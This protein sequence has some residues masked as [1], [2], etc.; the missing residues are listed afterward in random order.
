MHRA[1]VIKSFFGRRRPICL[2]KDPY[3]AANNDRQSYN[4]N[5]FRFH[6]FNFSP[7]VCAWR[8]IFRNNSRAQNSVEQGEKNLKCAGSGHTTGFNEAGSEKQGAVARVQRRAGGGKGNSGGRN[9]IRR[10]FRHGPNHQR[11]S[12][13]RN[14]I[15]CVGLRDGRRALRIGLGQGATTFLAATRRARNGCRHRTR[16]Q[17]QQW[18]R[19][20][21]DEQR[22]KQ[23]YQE[24][25]HFRR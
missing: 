23:N 13:K 21:A 19:G 20:G 12:D 8:K 3:H 15:L 1:S 24:L 7:A 10:I 4:Q 14:L 2:R 16:R 5:S 25:F 22:T 17:S 18:R 9:F 6:I 11:R